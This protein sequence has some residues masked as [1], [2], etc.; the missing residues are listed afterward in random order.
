M[1]V[2]FTDIDSVKLLAQTEEVMVQQPEVVSA[3]ELAAE[4]HGIYRCVS[5]V[6]TVL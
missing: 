4:P 5:C 6:T 1:H 2:T 3:G